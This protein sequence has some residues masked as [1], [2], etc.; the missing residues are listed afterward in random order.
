MVSVNE[1][2]GIERVKWMMVLDGVIG[3]EVWCGFGVDG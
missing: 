1:C 2:G 3:N